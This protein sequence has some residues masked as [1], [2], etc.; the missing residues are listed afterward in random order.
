MAVFEYKLYFSAYIFIS[1]NFFKIE[2]QG[3]NVI[4][5][6][7]TRFRYKAAWF[8]EGTYVSRTFEA[9]WKSKRLITD[10][11]NGV[12]SNISIT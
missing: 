6:L 4:K 7:K 10:I 9:N 5:R 12:V 1:L 2:F 11:A 3:N 8:C